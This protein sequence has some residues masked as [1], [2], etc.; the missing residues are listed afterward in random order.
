MYSK[1]VLIDHKEVRDWSFSQILVSILGLVM[2]GIFLF[3]RFN[4]PNNVQSMNLPPY[5]PVIGVTAF[6]Q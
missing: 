2:G 3:I 6:L 5:A 1:V 4:T